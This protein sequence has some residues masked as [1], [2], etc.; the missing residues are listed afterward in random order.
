[1]REFFNLM[2]G[3]KQGCIMSP[4]LFSVYME[5]I[6]GRV[7]DAGIP[8]MRERKVWRVP[9]LLFADDTVS[10]SEDEW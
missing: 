10:I 5:E 6:Q 9:V 4:W 8:L 3:L 2:V 7:V 1:M